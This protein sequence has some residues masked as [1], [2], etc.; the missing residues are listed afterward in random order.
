[1]FSQKFRTAHCFE[2]IFAQIFIIKNVIMLANL[3]HK[4]NL[5]TKLLIII[6]Y[7][8]SNWLQIKQASLGLI[9]TI[10]QERMV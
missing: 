9:E 1:M 6:G 5:G 4:D 2:I 8:C 7:Y 10:L 3:G